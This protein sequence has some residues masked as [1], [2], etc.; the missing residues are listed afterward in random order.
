M[1]ARLHVL[2]FT[3]CV[4]CSEKQPATTTAAPSPEPGTFAEATRP[5]TGEPT[6]PAP[7]AAPVTDVA[8]PSGVDWTAR[9]RVAHEVEIE[10][11]P[12]TVEVPEGLPRDPRSGDWN[13]TSSAADELPKVVLS[14]LDADR[15]NN[16]EKAKYHATL[17]SRTKTWTRTDER[18]DGYALTNAEP[19][20]TH[21]EA[22][23]Y[24]RSGDNFVRCK[25]SQL[26]D[27]PIPSHGKA[28][29]MLESICDSLKLR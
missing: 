25:A 26:S 12:V 21:I 23:R 9:K 20:K 17:S 3:V 24:L 10:G 16:V 14:K 28:L 2:I 4:G 5:E 27:N 15:I 8:I 6:K 7:G 1:N 19:D 22:I 29:S 11:I 13:I 18:P